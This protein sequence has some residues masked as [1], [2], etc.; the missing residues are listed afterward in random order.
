ML[1]TAFAFND[2]VPELGQVVLAFT[3]VISEPLGNRHTLRIGI[4]TRNVKD[5]FGLR[6]EWSG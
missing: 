4:L 3:V 5:D 1:L 2:D 6:H